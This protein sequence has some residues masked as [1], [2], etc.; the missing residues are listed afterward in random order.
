MDKCINI[1]NGKVKEIAA[2]LGVIP[3]IA[4]IKMEIWMN[5][6]GGKIPSAEDLVNSKVAFQNV[7]SKGIIASEKTI[8]DLAA[9]L[10]DRIG[11]P[12]KFESDRTKQYKG[13]IENNIAYINLAYATLDT[14]IHEI[15]GHPIIRAIK[16]R[17]GKDGEFDWSTG[18]KT[19]GTKSELYLN[20]LKELETGKGKAVLDRIK[21]D[22]VNKHDYIIEE[23][24]G[25][26]QVFS[27]TKGTLGGFNTK[28]EAQAEL[29]ELPKYTLEEQ[30][31][32]AIVELLGLMTAEKLDNV[33]DGKLI[34]LLKRLLKEMK[35]FMKQLLG[36]KEVE[37]D[38][39][40]DNMT[41]NDLAD[42][43]AYSNSKLILPGYEVE[44]T[45][46]D[47]MK[48]K[49]YQE[50]SNH[51]SQL[52]KSVEDVDLDNINVKNAYLN[53]EFYEVPEGDEGFADPFG[54]M[55][56]KTVNKNPI[57][58][59]I[60]KNKEY[61]QSKEIIEE[62]KKVNNIQYN[63]EEIY[64]RGQ[65]FSSVVGA[66]SSFDVNLMMQNLLQHIEDNK[67]A[68]GSF[69][70]SAYTKPVDKQIGHLEGGGGKIKFK[71]YPQSNDILWAANTDV[72]S[73]SV[74]DAS[75][76]V[77]KDKKSE[78]LGVS[79]TK[80]PSLQNVNTIQPNLAS[81]VDNLAHHHNELGISLNGTNFRLE[82][83]EDI[84]YQ[85]KKIID[86]IN[87]ILDQKYGKLVKPEIKEKNIKEDITY[88]LMLLDEDGYPKATLKK[89]FKTLEDA[90]QFGEENK[91][92]YIKWSGSYKYEKVVTKIT[93][94]QPTQTKD[95][96][97]ESIDSVKNKLK[98][99]ITD[100]YGTEYKLTGVPV[101]QFPNNKI[102]DTIK[103]KGYDYKIIAQIAEQEDW[104]GSI[105]PE[106]WKIEFV[107]IDSKKEYTEQ[108]LINTKI[109]KLKE[110][111]KKYP[112]S[113]IR[114]QVVQNK[115]IV[116]NPVYYDLFDEP[117]FQKVTANTALQQN[118]V[119]KLTSLQG[120]QSQFDTYYTVEG[121][122]TKLGRP[123]TLSKKNIQ[124]RE[125]YK[126]EE[127]VKQQ[128]KFMASGTFLHDIMSEIVRREF[129]EENKHRAPMTI[130]P[131]MSSYY[132]TMEE[133]MAPIIKEAKD[134]GDV[135]LTEVFVANLKNEN[136]GTIDLLAVTPKGNYRIYDLKN[137][138]R[139]DR[140]NL[141]R[142]N[143]IGEFSRQ[144]EI[145]KTILEDGDEKL[146]IP[147]GKV[148][149]TLVLENKVSYNDAKGVITKI[150]GIT[151][152]APDFL[153]T[154]DDKI[155][156]L[157]V[158]LTAQLE[159][160]AKKA[161]QDTNTL[162]K[163]TTNKLL[164]SKMELLQGLQLRQDVN[165]LIEHAEQELAY[166]KIYLKDE[167]NLDTSGVISEL[168]LY[169]D[170]VSFVDTNK[171]TPEMDKRL[172]LVQYE[173]KKIKNA[174]L[175]RQKEILIATAGEM[176]TTGN[177][178]LVD[179]LF[180]PIK[181]EN[182]IRKFT[183][184]IGEVDNALVQTA[185]RVYNNSIEKVA[186]KMDVLKEKFLGVLNRYEKVVGSKNFDILL[187]NKKTA[188][189]TEFSSEFWDAFSKNRKNFDKE[190]AKENLDYDKDAYE[191]ALADFE[192]YQDAYKE[193]QMKRIEV[194]QS[195]KGFT[196]DELAR[197][198]YGLYWAIREKDKNDW[199]VQNK[200]NPYQYFKAKP[201]WTDPKWKEIKQGKYKG[202][203]VEEFYNFYT[204]YMK[205]ANEIAPEKIRP[206]FIANFSQDFLE[207][208]SNLGMIGAIK[209]GWSELLNSLDLKYDEALF[210]KVVPTTG[211]QIRENFIPGL[212]DAKQLKSTDLGKSFLMFMEGVFRYDEI[213]KI[214]STMSNIKYQLRNVSEQRLDSQGNP[215]VGGVTEKVNTSKGISE[216][217]EYMIDAL[218]YGKKQK[219]EGSF[220]ITG[221]GLTSAMGLLGK[222]ETKTI[223][224]AK[225]VDKMIRYTGLRN[226]AFNIYAPIVNILGGTAN[227]YITGAGGLDYTAGDL[228]KAIGLITAGKFKFQSVEGQKMRL[229]LEW[230]R[231]DKEKID[232]DIFRKVTNNT[233]S[234]ILDEYNGMTGMRESEAAMVES[235]AAAMI[236]SGKH[237]VK[238]EDFD[239]VDGK[240][241]FKKEFNSI[242]KSMFKQK[243]M[244]VNS[245]TI[246]AMNPDDVM[247]AK[248]YML[249]RMLMQH[250]SWLPAQAF[251]RFGSRQFN[252]VLERYTEG[253]Y[254]VA[255]R[256]F[257]SIMSKG[258]SRGMESLT[259]EEEAAAKEAFAEATIILG[260][261]LLLA[262]LHAVD[263]DDKKEA[264]YKMTN[265]VSTRVLG[266]L[267][268]FADPTLQSQWAILQSPAASTSAIEDAG[269]LV[270]DIFRE[271]S[272][273][274]QEDPEKVR[275]KA[276]PG[277]KAIKMIPYLSKT[278]SFLDDLYNEDVKK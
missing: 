36:Q 233:S 112:R 52:A 120:K 95:N 190:W 74:W 206:G 85:T 234:A 103:L 232:R 121:F 87:S 255:V 37:I 218:I 176:D 240:L 55:E 25:V 68:G 39:L 205:L 56:Y 194:I 204:S 63:P 266:E 3:S 18:G 245:K 273:P 180:A 34:S 187:N 144:L 38:K 141:T 156:S 129:P 159:I 22:Y 184:G 90:K 46:P 248:K 31:E 275:K 162:Q 40:P 167:T 122:E 8:R 268:F 49:T 256:A 83:D 21:R 92:N 44:Y 153:M 75:E 219:D 14:P 250:R 16:N 11:I 76:K 97:K 179:N 149:S 130:T 278:K 33:K 65:E 200:N 60:E 91:D 238:F 23:E 228:T 161:K 77:N 131:D 160:L 69:A 216:K 257:K 169:T 201:K 100:E 246:G 35:A 168:D 212:G 119:N 116:D 20:L 1:N 88:D 107:K 209:G 15:L 150:N 24:F 123:S 172:G 9:R 154:T 61:E 158:K 113:L 126:T 185:F 42:L 110:V 78:L 199:L 262:A 174:F 128:E 86:S 252:Y 171:L 143:K 17:A 148:E 51:I 263:D 10:S 127:E 243:I 71:L 45:T 79:Y 258:V 64:S 208:V 239:V 249:G 29:N 227:M 183:T 84:P 186:E 277:E 223:A 230:L 115:I 73:G 225:L 136:G 6:N 140:T 164:K 203:A 124:G 66:Y 59:F 177:A 139:P 269:R 175:E 189:V 272:A 70:I 170:L 265:K 193:T 215:V 261:M 4:A 109:A 104:D 213:S 101:T 155:N 2:K 188:L 214:E 242:A 105:E 114:S 165:S 251:A 117:A 53:N 26:F 99:S 157:I 220:Q 54:T 222:G 134:N 43:L 173:A 247:L 267:F 30:Q 111:A 5:N 210:G 236:L 211:E 207:K 96:L 221:N 118:A 13:K 196:G 244:A 264:W 217:L 276:K 138:Y 50:A 237:S 62:W 271:A 12:V 72:Y 7:N 191:K 270:R 254:R 202:T 67:K 48:F 178:K 166:I 229:I 108:A 274:F 226:L 133:F 253:R 195:N 198:T 28:E 146:G 142:Y 93:G 57:V 260:T 224:Y 152:V 192:A 19:A 27:P 197:E 94:I 135:L 259:P 231:L 106:M 145:Y 102:G 137:R 89:G 41:I 163:E 147:K 235:G 132:S 151:V 47:N 182:A 81:I 58:D 98:G 181:D 82:Y 241:V 125:Q 80:Y 32:E